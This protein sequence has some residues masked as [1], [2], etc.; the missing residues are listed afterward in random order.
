MLNEAGR[1]APYYF[2]DPDAVGM[3][4]VLGN[5]GLLAAGFVGLGYV[6]SAL[7][8]VAVAARELTD[9]V[10]TSPTANTP[11]VV[12]SSSSG[13]L[14]SAHRPAACSG[15]PVSTKAQGSIPA[16]PGGCT[17]ARPRR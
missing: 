6:I 10:R 4:A 11:G 14:S 2:L 5:I 8:R 13:S 16:A 12:V 9:V 1:R 3:A 15:S 17:R 7:G